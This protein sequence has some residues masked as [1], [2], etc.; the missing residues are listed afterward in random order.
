MNKKILY[1]AALIAAVLM[2]NTPLVLAGAGP[3]ADVTATAGTTETLTATPV[4]VTLGAGPVIAESSALIMP[5]NQTYRAEIGVPPLMM[6]NNAGSV[7]VVGFVPASSKTSLLGYYT[8]AQFN[9]HGMTCNCYLFDLPYVSKR[10]EEGAYTM[11]T[12]VYNNMWGLSFPRHYVTN[13]TLV[14]LN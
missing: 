6:P 10:T 2:L 5:V 14:R 9:A 11:H 1:V 4:A 13:V 12:I 3:E 7:V 8:Q